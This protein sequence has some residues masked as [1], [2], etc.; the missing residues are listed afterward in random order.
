MRWGLRAWGDAHLHSLAEALHALA[1]AGRLGRQLRERGAG[2]EEQ[3][4]E[5]E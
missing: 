1:Q 4:G 5:E 2:G 3:E